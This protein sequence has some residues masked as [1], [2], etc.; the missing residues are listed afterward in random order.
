MSHEQYVRELENEVT[1]LRQ[2]HQKCL[3]VAQVS[4]PS[5]S[6]FSPPSPPLTFSSPLSDD[7]FDIVEDGA[8]EGTT[9]MR[10]K[11]FN[12]FENFI[13]TNGR[14]ET[15]SKPLGPGNCDWNCQ[16]QNNDSNDISSLELRARPLVSVAAD[17]R[18]IWQKWAD[19][20]LTSIPKG[21]Q[22]TTKRNELGL[23][24]IGDFNFT[25]RF[26]LGVSENPHA[27]STIFT[28]SLSWVEKAEQYARITQRTC[29]KVRLMQ[30]IHSYQKLVFVSLCAVL[31]IQYPDSVEDINTAMR[32]FLTKSKDAYLRRLRRGAL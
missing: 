7:L 12:S 26:L 1:W 27:S 8:R 24:T 15:R 30:H 31:E 9:H 16:R 2:H 20:F 6:L 11:T 3:G 5:T 23:N 19:E 13:Q 10:P 25:I 21:S 29:K 17:K 4:S 28:S 18:D 14:H 32:I 22:W